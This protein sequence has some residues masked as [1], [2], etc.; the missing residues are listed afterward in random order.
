M[1]RGYLVAM[2]SVE[3]AVS[4]DIKG[5]PHLS[6]AFKKKCSWV[7]MEPQEPRWTPQLTPPSLFPLSETGLL[8]PALG[9]PV[10]VARCNR[11][12]AA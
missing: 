10:V 3:L 12:W 5:R 8:K 7:E 4:G 9:A 1:H 6:L 2:N 11:V